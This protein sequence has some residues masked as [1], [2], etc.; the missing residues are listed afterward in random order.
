MSELGDLIERL[1]ENYMRENDW[2]RRRAHRKALAVV[3]RKARGLWTE[4]SP[5]QRG[6]AKT[7]RRLHWSVLFTRGWPWAEK[8]LWLIVGAGIGYV[9]FVK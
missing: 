5:V 1:T 7:I 9:L 8:V 4:R 3:R 2:P 6:I